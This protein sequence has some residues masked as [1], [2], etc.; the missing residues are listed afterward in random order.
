MNDK[1]TLL[2]SKLPSG[3][4][5]KD[6]LN[7][8]KRSIELQ[9]YIDNFIPEIKNLSQEETGN[10]Y[11]IDLG[12]GPGDFLEIC[13][14]YGFN[15]KGYD[16][17]L[18]SIKGMG[19]DYVNLCAIYVKEKDI[20]IDYCDFEETGFNCIEDNSVYLINSRGSFEQIFSKYL[21]GTPHHETHKSNQEWSHTD[22]MYSKL[23]TFFLDCSNKLI[24]NG[25]LLI[26]FN[27][28]KC[29]SLHN[30]INKLLPNTLHIQHSEPRILKVI[31]I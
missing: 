3:V 22:E 24:K 10:K 23:K 18:D 8:E 21:I 15:I 27:G 5:L 14:K 19:M 25:I 4:V 17:K 31:K 30:I 28:T 6:K 12:P 20:P 11:V 26:A 2:N 7:M 1:N 29:N 13:R 9:N 16:A